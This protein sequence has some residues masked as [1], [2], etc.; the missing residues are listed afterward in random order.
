MNNNSTIMFEGFTDQSLNFLKALG[1][2]QNREWFQENKKL[3]ENV[4]K[5]PMGDL[6]EE[7]SKRFSQIDIPLHGSRKASMFRIN[8]DVRFSKN[9]APYN[10]HISAV[11]TRNGTKKDGSG[12]Y[13]HFTPDNCF[14]AAGIWYPEAKQLRALRD[15]I[16]RY[17]DDFI[18]IENKLAQKGL[19][20][21]ADNALKRAPPAFK[22][23]EDENLQRLL[24]QKSFVV[25]RKIA[26]RDIEKPE[27]IETL[28]Q[29]TKDTMP[30]MEFCWRAMDPVRDLNDG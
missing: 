3:Y 11:L 21:N 6:I 9:K 30:L 22:H 24:K 29:I 28:V 26:D 7:A 27:L 2:H 17:A 4:I 12:A 10:T 13:M 16:V 20:F 25:E 18:R 15:A 19:A 1:F 23:I 8:R 5:N 14:F